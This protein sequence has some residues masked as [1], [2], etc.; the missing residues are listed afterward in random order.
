MQTGQAATPLDGRHSLAVD[1]RPQLSRAVASRV[2]CRP[3]SDAV[4]APRYRHSLYQARSISPRDPRG[5]RLL[6][7]LPAG[8]GQEIVHGARYRRPP[9]CRPPGPQIHWWRPENQGRASRQ[10]VRGRM[11]LREQARNLVGR[12]LPWLRAAADTGAL[13]LASHLLVPHRRQAS[14]EKSGPNRAVRGAPTALRRRGRGSGRVPC[15]SRHRWA[16]WRDPIA[17]VLDAAF[18]SRWPS[19][20]RQDALRRDA[21][22]RIPRRGARANGIVRLAH[23]LG[24]HPGSRAD[25]EPLLI[26][27]TVRHS[28]APARRNTV[29][30]QARECHQ[31][32]VEL[33]QNRKDCRQKGLLPDLRA[34]LRP[35]ENEAP[36]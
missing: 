32:V 11:R 31:D 7:S 33:P 20:R 28:A 3:W 35:K 36:H 27:R 6:R 19:R 24:P 2:A 1:V 23:R 17:A 9:R 34:D 21:P 30:R 10:M 22:E 16:F 12:L 25:P 26:G 13:G 14:T 8:R 4:R 18:D 5:G 29:L 15:G